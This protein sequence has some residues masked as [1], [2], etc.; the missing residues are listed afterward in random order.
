MNKLSSNR[1]PAKWAAAL[2]LSLAALYL[3]LNGFNSA[4]V[5]LDCGDVRYKFLGITTSEIRLP[6]H[7][8]SDL[9]AIAKT[10]SKL[11][12]EWIWIEHGGTHNPDRMC[13]DFYR[14]AAAWTKV[15]PTITRLL[16]ED[17]ADYIRNEH[18]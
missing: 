4:T 2:I 13:A 7:E 3:I 10:S 18:W 17:S 1:R 16:L 9:I 5:R 12:P 15:D 14:Q 8:R 11:S 6:E